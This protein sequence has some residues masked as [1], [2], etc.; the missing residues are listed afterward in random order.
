V[1]NTNLP[2]ILQEL[3]GDEIA[4][5][6]FFYDDIVHAEASAYTHWTDFLVPTLTKHL[7][8]Y[9]MIWYDMMDYINVRPKADV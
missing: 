9:D 1:I 5:V 6:N 7:Q 2:P 8:I 3:I 4:N